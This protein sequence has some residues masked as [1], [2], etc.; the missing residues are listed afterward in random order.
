MST[1]GIKVNMTP[2]HPGDFIRA[3]II[4]ELG[5]TVTKA[6]EILGVRRATFSNLLH[7]ASALSP[8]MA[9]RLEKAFGGKH[10]HVASYA[11]MA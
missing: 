3:E 2:A 4:E 9:L 1:D 10:G 6:A 5:L 8:E 11:G 7:G